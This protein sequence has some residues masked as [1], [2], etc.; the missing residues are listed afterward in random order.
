MRDFRHRV[1]RLQLAGGQGYRA[2]RPLCDR[3]QRHLADAIPGIC[4]SLGLV[5]AEL[6]VQDQS[7]S[8][9]HGKRA[10]RGFRIAH[11]NADK[12]ARCSPGRRAVLQAPKPARRAEFL[13]RQAVSAPRRRNMPV[14]LVT[15]RNRNKA[16]VVGHSSGASGN[17]HLGPPSRGRAASQRGNQRRGRRDGSARHSPYNNLCRTVQNVK[18]S[19]VS[20]V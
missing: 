15:E 12:R 14:R 9:P 18:H 11:Q 10:A 3:A 2:R 16:A 7:L 8:G 20:K 19:A 6:Q 17:V 1:G 4:A 5:A 13:T